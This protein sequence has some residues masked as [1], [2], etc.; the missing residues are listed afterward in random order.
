M[1]LTEVQINNFK[2]INDL[3]LKISDNVTCLIG[4]NETGKSNILKAIK[5]LNFNGNQLETSLTSYTMQNRSKSSFPTIKAAFSISDNEPI[6]EYIKANDIGSILS[7]NIAKPTKLELKISGPTKK[8]IEMIVSFDDGD[9]E[10]LNHD[11]NDKENDFVISKISEFLPNIEYFEREEFTINPLNQTAL[12]SNASDVSSQAFK[13][14]LTLGGVKDFGVLASGDPQEIN[15]LKE[16]IAFRINDILRRYYKQNAEIEIKIDSHNGVYTLHFKD[17]FRKLNSFDDRST[18]FQY[19]FSFLINKIYLKE[20]TG[21]NSI[22]LFD[23]PALVL[24]PT[25]QKD[26]IKLLDELA[27]DNQIFYTTHSPFSINRLKPKRVLAVEKT[28]ERGTYINPKPYLHNWRALRTSLGMDIADSF[29]YADK[30]LLVEG[31]EDKIYFSSLINYFSNN[32]II[33]LTTDVFS[34]VDAGSASNFPAMVQILLDEERPLVVL[35]DS[36]VKIELNRIKKKEAE[37]KNSN[38]L[39]V[40]QVNE[41][42]KDALAI[43]DILPIKLYEQACMNYIQYLVHENVLTPR[44]DNPPVLSLKDSGKLYDQIATHVNTHYTQADMQENKRVPVSKVGI[45]NEFDKL[46]YAGTSDKTKL[47]SDFNT[48]IDL[49]KKVGGYLRIFA[50]K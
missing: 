31:P 2:S 18:G 41:V 49:I 24:H 6:A 23:E 11:S 50:S 16:D 13:R 40:I 34:I 38:V 32:G 8:D 48:S 22:F 7:G 19:F 9:Q 17:E 43:E 33:D 36:D 39:K 3:T 5:Y 26:F 35:I 30:T 37:I 42:K 10:K 4:K 27:I 28:K 25:G 12:V 15:E 20:F 1:L 44:P 45:A 29:F 47:Q 46:L 21:K 14:L